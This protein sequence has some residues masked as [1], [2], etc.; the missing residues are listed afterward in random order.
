MSI[1]LSGKVA[2]ITGASRGIGLAVARRLI[3]AGATVVLNSRNF[4]A[5]VAD[6]L[7][8]SAPDRVSVQAGDMADPEAA[9]QL[10]RAVFARHKRLDALVNNA[11]T[12]RA[13][14]I[15]MISDEDMRATLDLNLAAPMHLIQAAARL[16]ARSGGSIVN[17]A[18]VVGLE[19]AAG[20][21]AYAASKA[22]VIGATRA[23]AKEL[24]SKGVRVNAVAPGYIETEMTAGLGDEVRAQ[25][26]K[27]IGL[28]RAGTPEDV[29]DAV[30]FLCSDMSRYI[31]GQVL[32]VD[33]GMVI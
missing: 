26:L 12:M 14:M 19:G 28:G 1:D 13:A 6:E 20:Q 25:S 10:V 23:A 21:M 33:G 32:R 4:D 29:A 18:S 5:S 30:L 9:R 15:G 17:V 22:G 3:A 7:A 16:L 27:A 11:G 8:A 2:L 31:T 24:A